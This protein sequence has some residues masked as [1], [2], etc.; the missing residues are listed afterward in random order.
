[1]LDIS[2][3]YLPSNLT[4]EVRTWSIDEM[5][6]TAKICD[7]A[8]IPSDPNDPQKAGVSSNRLIT[9]LA[10]GLPTA[11]DIISSYKEFNEFFIDIRSK[12]FLNLLNN[13]DYF[14][15][16]VF[17][18]QKE[19]VPLF[20]QDIICQKWIDFFSKLKSFNQ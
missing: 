14:H 11:A 4:L 18:A 5:I 3:F 8:I 12:Q 17:K 13:P 7:L 10:L 1:M 20:F 19:I 2:K 15:S 6:H 9:A 16:Q